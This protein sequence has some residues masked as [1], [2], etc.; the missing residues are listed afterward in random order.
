MGRVFIL[1]GCWFMFWIA[2]GVAFG[3]MTKGLDGMFAGATNGAWIAALLS[4]AWPF[5]MPDSLDRWTKG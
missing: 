4:F 5:I 2:A 1:V 3:L